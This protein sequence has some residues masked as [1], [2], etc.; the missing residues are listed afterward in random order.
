MMSK[1]EIQKKIDYYM[2]LP[3]SVLLHEVEDEGH[4]YWIAE[5]P[6]LPGCK[7]HG[8][9][10]EEAVNSVEEAKKDWILDSLGK[11]ED[12]PTPVERDRYSGKTLVRMSSSLHRALSLMAEHEN[13][14]LN[15]LMVTILAK[16]VGRFSV[17]NR[18]EHKIDNL[19]GRMDDVLQQQ[20]GT[21]PKL[22]RILLQ[23]YEHEHDFRVNTSPNIEYQFAANVAEYNQCFG[24]AVGPVKRNFSLP[25]TATAM[26]HDS[27]KS[28]GLESLVEV[29]SK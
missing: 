23:P 24:V 21:S 10:V 14:S 17:L 25:M 29:G 7:S 19:L 4:K 22:V 3:Y 8:S 26:V 11:G 27:V 6:E 5:V 1:V 15:Q 28:K 16:E 20:I 13:L 12:V 18:V 2:Q 9:T